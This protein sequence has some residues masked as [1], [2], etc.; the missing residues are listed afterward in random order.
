MTRLH[1]EPMLRRLKRSVV[2]G[3]TLF[4]ITQFLYQLIEFSTFNITS[5]EESQQLL[6]DGFELHLQQH[7]SKLSRGTSLHENSNSVLRTQSIGDTSN[8]SKSLLTHRVLSS[9]DKYADAHSNNHNKIVI[10]DRHL[11]ATN[12]S[13]MTPIGADTRLPATCPS[14]GLPAIPGPTSAWQVVVESHSYVFSAFMER[15]L[16]RREIKVVGTADTRR[17][18][19]PNFCHIWY[20]NYSYPIVVNAVDEI[21]PETHN[22]R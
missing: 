14:V 18:G 11:G 16:D 1:V 4:C 12:S 6:K 5:T 15:R 22:R 21:V 8:A 9:L 13:D 17:K 2:G 10:T 3:A 20:K 7:Q 19:K